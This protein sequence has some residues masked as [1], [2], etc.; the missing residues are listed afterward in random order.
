MLQEKDTHW[1]R[2][3]K[4]QVKEFVLSNFEMFKQTK[5]PDM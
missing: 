4:G 5:T 1:I 2:V 3:E